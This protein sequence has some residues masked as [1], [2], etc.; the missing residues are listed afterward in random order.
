[1]EEFMSVI[2]GVSAWDFCRLLLLP[3]AF[4]VAPVGSL[5]TVVALFLVFLFAIKLST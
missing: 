1:M 2:R 5:R 4:I 3:I